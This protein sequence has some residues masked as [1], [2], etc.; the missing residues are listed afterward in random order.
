MMPPVTTVLGE[1]HLYTWGVLP[2]LIFLAR[3]CDV[4]LGTIR[5]V[6]VSKGF[7]H[8]APL[9]GFLEILI[10]IVAIGQIMQ[11]LANPMCYLGYAGG[12]AMGNYIGF[13]VASVMRGWL[14]G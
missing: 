7:K 2:L 11:N 4:T 12:F 6:F 3:V 1:S 8:L 13:I 10:W 5:L 14:G 9:I